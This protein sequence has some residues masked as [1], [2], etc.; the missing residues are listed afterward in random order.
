MS[1]DQFGDFSDDDKF[2][3][4]SNDHNNDYEDY[5]SKTEN[6]L[7]QLAFYMRLKFYTLIIKYL[8][9]VDSIKPIRYRPQT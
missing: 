7:Q 6:I 3:L 1:G 4:D 2:R 8:R 5:N 9:A